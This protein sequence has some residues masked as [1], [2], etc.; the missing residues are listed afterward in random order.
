[1]QT[2]FVSG[3]EVSLLKFLYVLENSDPLQRKVLSVVDEANRQVIPTPFHISL[4][5]A[6]EWVKIRNAMIFLW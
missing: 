4:S 2:R 5:T 6:C 1:M 3:N